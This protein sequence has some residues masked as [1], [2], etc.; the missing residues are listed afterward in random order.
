MTLGTY[1]EFWELMPAGIKMKE[2]F[3][4]ANRPRATST[5]NH[6]THQVPQHQHQ[7][8]AFFL[9]PT[10]PVTQTMQ[11]KPLVPVVEGGVE[12]TQTSP[13]EEDDGIYQTIEISNLSQ[14]LT[15]QNLREVFKIVGTIDEVIIKFIFG[16][17]RVCIIRYK[18]ASM[19]EAAKMLS[20]HEFDGSAL[21]IKL[22]NEK[23]WLY[24]KNTSDQVKYPSPLFLFLFLFP[25]LPYS[26]P[27]FGRKSCEGAIMRVSFC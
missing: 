6:L 26:L 22:I 21:R 23:E 2:M 18:E 16:K 10:E 12:P 4:L 19:A 27:S 14:G 11:T 5:L 3:C 24:H 8:I 13:N 17:G 7:D 20:G 9:W 25:P 1:E 15:E